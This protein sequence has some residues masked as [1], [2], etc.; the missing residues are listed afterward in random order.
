MRH[1]RPLSITRL[2]LVRHG[3]SVV[4]A[5]ASNRQEGAQMTVLPGK[6][7]TIGLALVVGLTLLIIGPQALVDRSQSLTSDAGPFDLSFTIG[8]DSYQGAFAP[9]QRQAHD[10]ALV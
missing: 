1:H 7:L 9:L 5:S 4:G 3:L 8:A 10:H 2:A 6:P